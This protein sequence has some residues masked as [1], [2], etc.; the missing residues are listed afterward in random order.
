[1]PI[2]KGLIPVPP[3]VEPVPVRTVVPAPG[4]YRAV[5]IAPDGTELDLNPSP[6]DGLGGGLFSLKAN[7]GLGAVP[8]QH[9]TTDNPAGGVIVEAT[10]PQERTILWPVR[11]RASTHLGLLDLWR[12]VT[13]LFT[14]TRDLGPGR[15]RLTRPDGSARE[16]LAYYSSG[17]EG[18]PEDGTWLQVTGVINLLA[19]DP[20]WTATTQVVQ[21]YKEA[22][23]PTYLDPY[24]TVSSGRVFGASSVPN[25][26]DRAV[27]PT[28]T[29]RGPMTALVATN[30][31]RDEFFTVTHTLAAGELLTITGRP[32]EVRGPAGENL[33][34]ALG[35]TTG[36]GK[37]WRLDP[38]TVTDVT[39]FLTGSA[40]DTTA[41][42]NDGTRVRLSYPLDYET[43]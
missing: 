41:T 29:I 14:Q 19:P 32:I 42:S 6:G 39:F 37:P 31:T 7:A 16:I 2:L 34:A 11:M 40:P 35:L 25:T 9:I 23:R 43:A 27:W 28:W 20:F 36:G 12:Y 1:V 15:L 30:V 26:G 4:I 8:V 5:W 3:V 18:E 13:R 38:R 24:M 17:L 21:E 10:R 22:I 33:V